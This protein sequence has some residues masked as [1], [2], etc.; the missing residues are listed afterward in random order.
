MRFDKVLSGVCNTR[1]LDTMNYTNQVYVHANY[2]LI[3]IYA[4][5]NRQPIKKRLMFLSGYGPIAIADWSIIVQCHL[6][7]KHGFKRLLVQSLKWAYWGTLK[8]LLMESTGEHVQ[9][10]SVRTYNYFQQE[11]SSLIAIAQPWSYESGNIAKI[12]QILYPLDEIRVTIRRYGLFVA[13]CQ[14]FT[15]DMLSIRVRKGFKQR[16]TIFILLPSL[17]RWISS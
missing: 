3:F 13:G 9:R 8:R 15:F 16:H 11:C 1:I 7:V 10:E 6:L 5:S 2:T 14:I 4:L 12:F 17:Y